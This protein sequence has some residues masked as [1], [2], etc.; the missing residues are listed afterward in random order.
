M[1]RGSFVTMSCTV[2]S[3]VFQQTMCVHNRRRFIPIGLKPVEN[4]NLVLH[5]IL[6]SPIFGEDSGLVRE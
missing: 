6:E 4:A 2:S 3:I 1:A 5:D